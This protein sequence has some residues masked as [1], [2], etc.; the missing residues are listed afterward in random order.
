MHSIV[1]CSMHETASEESA[2]RKLSE[3]LKTNNSYTG[4]KYYLEVKL[5]V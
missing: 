1:H 2:R 4:V 3:A 5:N